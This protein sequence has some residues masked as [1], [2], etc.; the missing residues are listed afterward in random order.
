MPN[1]IVIGAAKAGTDALCSY[2][3]QHPDIFMS[4]N[5]E[6]MF[7]VADG[8]TEIPYRGPGDREVLARFEHWVP[9]LDRYRDLFAGVTTE[10]A[11]GEGSTW[12]LYDEQAPNRIQAQVPQARLIAVLRNPV[13]RAYSAY[14]MLLR[15]GRESLGD[16]ARALEAEDERVRRGWEPIWHYRRM[17]LYSQ[18]V[19]R[20]QDLFPADQLRFVIYDDFNAR[21]GDV[22][23]DLFRFLGVDAAFEPDTSQR[24][25]VSLVPRHQTYHRLVAGQ[26]RLKSILK[27]LLPSGLRQ[28]LRENLTAQ[29][30]MVAP[31]RLDPTRRAHL[32]ELFR[33]DILELQD[34][35]ARDLSVWLS[36]PS[37]GREHS[38]RTHGVAGEEGS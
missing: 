5:K 19:R 9:T 26:N 3:D 7:F 8:Q 33:E 29:E 22:L 14:T 6:P 10:K 30:E 24:H 35:L 12:Y 1:F 17:G 27:P 38:A 32:I 18:Q 2:L 34:L 36:P 20:Y 13:D 23:T 11:I 4:P 37:S 16:F 21:P 15:D 25:N 31:P 28:R